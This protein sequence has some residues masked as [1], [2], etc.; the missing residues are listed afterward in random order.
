MSFPQRAWANVEKAAVS[1]QAVRRRTCAWPKTSTLSFVEVAVVGCARAR[2]RDTESLLCDRYFLNYRQGW[3]G[4]RAKAH[5]VMTIRGFAYSNSSEMTSGITGKG[6]MKLKAVG[7]TVGMI[8]WLLVTVALIGDGSLDKV[9]VD[10]REAEIGDALLVGPRL[11]QRRLPTG[12][13]IDFGPAVPILVKGKAAYAARPDHSD[14]GRIESSPSTSAPRPPGSDEASPAQPPGPGDAGDGPQ[15]SGSLGSGGDPA[16]TASGP[17]DGVGDGGEGGADKV[18]GLVNET[19]GA[20]GDTVNG[21]AQGAGTAVGDAGSS[22]GDA[23]GSAGENGVADGVGEVVDG[24]AAA[25]GDA[26]DGVGGG[27]GGLIGGGGG[28]S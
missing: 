2:R 8:V 14:R 28:G 5:G 27:V 10:P 23:V 4:A 26:A 1:I 20:V 3:P 22:V 11:L 17:A 16:S 9:S 12:E 21:V 18:G 24:A 7:I 6:S 19:T 15:S 25:G 13:P